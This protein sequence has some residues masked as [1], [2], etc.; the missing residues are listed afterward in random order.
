MCIVIECYIQMRTEKCCILLNTFLVLMSPV[1]RM[2]YRH[3]FLKCDIATETEYERK[4]CWQGN[5][6]SSN[7]I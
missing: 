3:Q 5:N 1:I 2:A 7:Q 6:V 4:F